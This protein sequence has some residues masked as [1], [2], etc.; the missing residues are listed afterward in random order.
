MVSGTET[1]VDDLLVFGVDA[2]GLDDVGMIFGVIAEF[3]GA[4]VDLLEAEVTEAGFEL[5]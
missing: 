2:G 5:S 4:A 3:C 1:K